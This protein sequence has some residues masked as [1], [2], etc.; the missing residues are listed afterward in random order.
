[1]STIISTSSLSVTSLLPRLPIFFEESS[2]EDVVQDA[3][4]AALEVSD[5]DAFLAESETQ[6]FIVIKDD[7]ILLCRLTLFHRARG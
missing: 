2:S 6:A 5:F 1:V 3:F 4:E 7:K